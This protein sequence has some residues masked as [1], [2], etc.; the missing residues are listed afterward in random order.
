MGR[1]I[2]VRLYCIWYPDNSIANTIPTRNNI[3]SRIAHA[4]ILQFLKSLRELFIDIN[5]KFVSPESREICGNNAVRISIV[6]NDNC[7]YS[8]GI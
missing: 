5:R 4:N 2:E 3:F 8:V 1:L 7:Y 6:F